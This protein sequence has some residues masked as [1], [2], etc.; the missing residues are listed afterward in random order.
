[1]KYRRRFHKCTPLQMLECVRQCARQTNFP[2]EYT[3]LSFTVIVVVVVDV[4]STESAPGGWTGLKQWLIFY[5]QQQHSKRF[6]RVFR[7]A[8]K[9]PKSLELLYDHSDA[10]GRWLAVVHMCL[11]FNFFFFVCFV[12]LCITQIRIHRPSI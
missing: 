11:I 12:S 2:K 6:K 4:A 3:P 7:R 1:M 9:A 8:Q 10:A 5:K